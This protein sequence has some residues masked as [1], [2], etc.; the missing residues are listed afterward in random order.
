MN[1]Y[2]KLPL[3][4]KERGFQFDIEAIGNILD[5]L[6]I[7]MSDLHLIMGSNPFKA[8][9]V[10]VYE[11]IKKYAKKREEEIPTALEVEAWIEKDG[12]FEKNVANI[13]LAFGESI[14]SK[15]PQSAKEQAAPN[16]KKPAKK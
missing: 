4:G 3:A 9:P 14:Q 5:S 11:G 7:G 16:E 10:I 12:L 6:K 2:T 13:I 1:G 15:L 8:Y